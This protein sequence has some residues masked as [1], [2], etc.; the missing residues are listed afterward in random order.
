MHRHHHHLCILRPRRR[1]RHLPR[2][3]CGHWR[4][5]ACIVCT[6]AYLRRTRPEGLPGRELRARFKPCTRLLSLQ[7]PDPDPDAP[8][9][10]A[11]VGPPRRLGPRR[12][13]CC[14]GPGACRG[15]ARASRQ[16]SV[17]VRRAQTIV[18]GCISLMLRIRMFAS[19][20]SAGQVRYEI[21]FVAPGHP[22]LVAPRAVLYVTH[23]R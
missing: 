19:Q 18:G 23:V 13:G 10:V 8:S 12:A 5:Y 6:S 15:R 21:F 22:L 11:A 4:A 16:A 3:R 7:C 2:P 9:G 20:G 1:R 17:T 14:K